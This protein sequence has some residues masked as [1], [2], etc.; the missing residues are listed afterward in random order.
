M[1]NEFIEFVNGTLTIANKSQRV[2][3]VVP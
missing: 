3:K 1:A 2:V